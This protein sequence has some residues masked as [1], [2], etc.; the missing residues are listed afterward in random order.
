M[1]YPRGYHSA[2]ILLADGSVLMGGDKPGLWKSGETTPHERYFPSYY[3]MARPQIATAPAMVGY[4]ATF[5]V[6]SPT[7]RRSP[8]S[9]C[10]I[11]AQSR[12]DSTMSQRFIGCSIAGGGATSLQVEAPPD[13]TIAPPGPYLLFV[14]TSGGQFRPK[15]AGSASTVDVSRLF[16]RADWPANDGHMGLVVGVTQAASPLAF[17]WLDA[18][19]VYA[20]GLV[21]IA[22]VYVGFA[23]ADGRPRVLIAECAVATAFVVIAAVGVTVSPWLLVAGLAGHGFK[24]LWQHRKPARTTHTRP[25]S[26]SSRSSGRRPAPPTANPPTPPSRSAAATPPA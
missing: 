9:C 17:W 6:D 23:V 24:D 10:C 16:T 7:P 2:A 20:F 14:I 26:T 8:R 3:F 5:T 15:D 1:K 12:T 25:A 13:A 18:P 22:S 21:V 19:I 11:P 4:G